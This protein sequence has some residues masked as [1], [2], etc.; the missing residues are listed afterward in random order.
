[1]T[2]YIYL[3]IPP[4][5][6]TKMQRAKRILKCA[7]LWILGGVLLNAVLYALVGVL[8]LVAFLAGR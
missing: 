1:M 8:W 3:N 2:Q 6:L 7:G 5:K 4:P